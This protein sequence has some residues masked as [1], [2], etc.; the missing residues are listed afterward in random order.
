[1]AISSECDDDDEGNENLQPLYSKDEF[2]SY[3]ILGMFICFSTK[4]QRFWPWF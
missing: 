4:F 3:L 2:F 1:M